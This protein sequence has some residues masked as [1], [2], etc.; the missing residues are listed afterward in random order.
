MI[1]G[2][3][4]F[5]DADHSRGEQRYVIIGS[6]AIGRLMVLAYTEASATIIRIISARVA[7]TSEDSMKETQPKIV[8]ELRP[9]YDFASMQGGV[10]GKYV[11]R[12]RKGTN[13]V[14]IEPEVSEP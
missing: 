1:P 6:S 10:R 2:S 13:I 12:A 11:D 5:P 3:V 7:A 14:L 9:E 4:A 8:D